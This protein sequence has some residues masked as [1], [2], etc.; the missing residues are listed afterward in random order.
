[1]S[2][3]TFFQKKQVLLFTTL[4]IFL[5]NVGT[6]NLYGLRTIRW[7]KDENRKLIERVENLPRFANDRI[8]WIV[9]AQSFPNKT[10]CQCKQ[11][12][13]YVLKPKLGREFWTED[14]NQKLIEQVENLPRPTNG[15]IMWIIIIQSF[16]NKTSNQ[17]RRHWRYVLKPKLG[18][19]FWTEDE[20]Q[21][22][23]KAVEKYRDSDELPW[24]EIAE[25]L[26]DKQCW[27]CWHQLM[28]VLKPKLGEKFW[29]EDENQRLIEVIEKYRDSDELPWKEIAEALPGKQRWQCWHQLMCVLK[30]KLWKEFWSESEEGILRR[31]VFSACSLGI[32][33]PWG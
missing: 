30:P 17:C 31:A 16:P 24:K 15:R 23:I 10:P 4:S 25:A 11:R 26:P 6:E 14:E 2:V 5:S 27:Q 19:K 8:T 21:R 32:D 3:N 22:L 20:N 28:C 29:T 13:R 7:T 1:M 18:E 12:W 9:I 33:I